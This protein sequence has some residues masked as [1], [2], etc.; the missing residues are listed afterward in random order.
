M[1]AKMTM[2]DPLTDMIKPSKNGKSS[3]KIKL[4]L[5]NS[6]KLCL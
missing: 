1:N 3:L 4:I 2:L 5:K 6:D